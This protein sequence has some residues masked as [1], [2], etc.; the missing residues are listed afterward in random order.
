MTLPGD[1]A[2]INRVISIDSVWS[3]IIKD[4]SDQSCSREDTGARLDEDNFIT[5]QS[6][7]KKVSLFLS[8]SLFMGIGISF[9]RTFASCLNGRLCNAH[10]EGFDLIVNERD[11]IKINESRCSNLHL[12]LQPDN[13]YYIS[14][15]T[16]IKRQ[17]Q[18]QSRERSKWKQSSHCILCLV[19]ACLLPKWSFLTSL[20]EKTISKRWTLHLKYFY[21][22]TEWF[23][24]SFH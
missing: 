12:S 10:T 17:S 2:K 3:S 9:H 14:R 11:L 13:Y 24:G 4:S 19:K 22:E 15:C 20:T 5:L 21:L 16:W 6:R 8:F 18:K 1:Q 23:F 7:K